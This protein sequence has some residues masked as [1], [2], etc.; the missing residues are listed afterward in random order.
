MIKKNKKNKKNKL[1]RTKIG[2]L[3]AKSYQKSQSAANLRQ[4]DR[5]GHVGD[6]DGDDLF[7][8]DKDCKQAQA[9]RK[10]L[11]V[12][13]QMEGAGLFG[14]F[15]NSELPVPLRFEFPEYEPS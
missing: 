15:F 12:E 7:T 8:E 13:G 10:V 5:T 3:V 4:R 14:L 9:L 11:N 1:T 6:A 2:P